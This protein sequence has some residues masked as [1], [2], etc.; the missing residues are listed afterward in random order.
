MEQNKR[1]AK[2]ET[3]SV[4]HRALGEVGRE[5]GEL[6]YRHKLDANIA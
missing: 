6:V 3:P 5:G 4:E 2:G 1:G